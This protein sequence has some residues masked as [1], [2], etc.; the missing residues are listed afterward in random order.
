MYTV[1]WVAWDS[2]GCSDHWER[3]ENKSAVK[4][5]L[6]GNGLVNDPDVLIFGPEANNFI[7]SADEIMG[8]SDEAI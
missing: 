7:V 1:C 2:Y 8:G 4:D 3:C 5:L 6:I